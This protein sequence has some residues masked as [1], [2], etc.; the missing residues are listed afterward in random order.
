MSAIARVTLII[1]G[2]IGGAALGQVA[3]IEADVET[4]TALKIGAGRLAGTEETE[5]VRR[6]LAQLSSQGV[7]PA[8]LQYLR[9]IK[10]LNGNIHVR[11][12]QRHNDMAVLGGQMIVHLTSKSTRTTEWY[13]RRVVDTDSIPVITQTEAIAAARAPGYVASLARSELAILPGEATGGAAELVWRIVSNKT[14]AP[15]E[16]ETLVNARTGRVIRDAD[17]SARGYSNVRLRP[18]YMDRVEKWVGPTR[19]D[20]PESYYYTEYGCLGSTVKDQSLLPPSEWSQCLPG[21]A[22]RDAKGRYTTAGDLFRR[23]WPVTWGDFS[24]TGGDRATPAA[25]VL[26]QVFT[27]HSFFRNVFGWEGYAGNNDRMSFIV[28][29]GMQG[30]AWVTSCRCIQFGETLDGTSYAPV[31]Q[32]I[33]FHEWA[34]AVNENT[35]GMVAQAGYPET[36]GAAEAN[37]DI[38]ALLYTFDSN[39]TTQ[40]DKRGGWIGEMIYRENYSSGSWLGLNKAIRY[41]NDPARDGVSPACYSESNAI[42]LP[43]HRASLPLS[44]AMYLLVK[45]GTS[46][47]DGTAVAAISFTD[48]RRIWWH[49][50]IT[51]FGPGI[52]MADVRRG[53]IQSAIDQFG[54][55]SVQHNAVLSALNSVRIP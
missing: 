33:V 50:L 44:H 31:S 27:V 55:G 1:C 19:M 16:Q 53:T 52:T 42:N 41:L 21:Y 20:A 38:W 10:D 25:D 11:F 14:G 17:T 49:A 3:D 35:A 45:G 5:A 6:A 4:S 29:V 48:A 13:W 23:R 24:L 39:E 51:Y 26:F 15:D 32:D 40:T 54:D 47:C 8:N 9:S 34:H 2:W 43:A 7:S 22:V 28:H 37:S 18:M 46:K 30:A 36:G 12:S